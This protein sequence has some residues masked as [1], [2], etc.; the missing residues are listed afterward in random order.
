MALQFNYENDFG[1]TVSS[2]YAKV[3]DLRV[4]NE[5]VQF[6]LKIFGNEQARLDDKQ[7]LAYRSIEKPLEN[8][9]VSYQELYN[10]LKTL[11]EFAGATDA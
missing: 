5:T 10:Y 7:P 8:F 4:S 1:L 11:P 6:T 9:S 2:A 3:E